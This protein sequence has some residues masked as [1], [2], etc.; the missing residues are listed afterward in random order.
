MTGKLS[1]QGIIISQVKDNASGENA[2]SAGEGSQ[3]PF[4]ILFFSDADEKD[5]HNQKNKADKHLL[6]G[7]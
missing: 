5:A 4:K 3:H 1:P 2:K 6:A 7:G